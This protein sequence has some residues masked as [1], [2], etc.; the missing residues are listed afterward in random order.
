MYVELPVSLVAQLGNSSKI[1]LRSESEPIVVAFLI[2][3]Y[4]FYRVLHL[5][6]MLKNYFVNELRMSTLKIHMV[7]RYMCLA[8]LYDD[9]DNKT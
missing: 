4:L 3:T 1:M 2:N 9:G 8:Q 6:N 5:E 7:D